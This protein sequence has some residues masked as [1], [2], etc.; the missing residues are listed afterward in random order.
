M[1]GLSRGPWRCFA[2]S[3]ALWSSEL[4]LKDLSWDTQGWTQPSGASVT[5]AEAPWV[6]LGSREAPAA[7]T[8]QRAALWESRWLM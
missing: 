4:P 2:E 6:A 8:L 3:L 5:Q 7:P 1:R